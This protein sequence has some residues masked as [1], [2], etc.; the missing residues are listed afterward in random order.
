MW[1]LILAVLDFSR[2]FVL[3]IDAGAVA[4]GALLMQLSVKCGVAWQ[5]LF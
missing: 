3:D 4:A 5:L 2:A 1:T